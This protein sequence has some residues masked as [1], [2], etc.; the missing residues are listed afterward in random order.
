M[1]EPDIPVELERRF[2]QTESI[3]RYLT[4][5]MEEEGKVRIRKKGG[6]PGHRPDRRAQ[7]SEGNHRPKT[8][9]P[10]ETGSAPEPKPKA[11][12]E[13]QPESKAP[14]ETKPEPES[15]VKPE[16]ESKPAAEPESKPAAEPEPDAE[17]SPADPETT[18]EKEK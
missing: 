13:P 2:K 5:V 14:A 4:V 3:L 7:T 12:P 10:A 11:E 15:E 9:P 8:P 6:R 17:P 18:E 16:P 1:G